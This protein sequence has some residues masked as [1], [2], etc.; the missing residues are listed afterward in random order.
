M[1]S[2]IGSLRGRR[3]RDNDGGGSDDGARDPLASPENVFDYVQAVEKTLAENVRSLDRCV[4]G[5]CDRVSALEEACA[6]LEL[7]LAASP[8]PHLH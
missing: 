3:C 4:R 5:L 7:R 6:A 2:V 1:G 8:A